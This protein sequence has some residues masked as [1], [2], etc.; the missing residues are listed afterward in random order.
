M[1]QKFPEL[2]GGA[3]L[4]ATALVAAA[5]GAGIFAMATG[6]GA[7]GGGAIARTAGK[8]LPAGKT[9]LRGG[10]LG[11]GAMAGGAGLNAAFGEESAISRYGSSAL[12]GAATGAFIGSVVPVLGTAVG[13]AVG[14]GLGVG[15]ESIKDML[16]PSAEAP[17]MAADIKL[18]VSDERVRVASSNV[19]AS[20]MTGSVQTDTGN[21]W[22]MP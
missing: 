9:L 8:Y 2:T 1:A 6:G 5:G 18:S 17:K 19:T 16:K 4:A 15:W 11:V 7:G 10:A 12:N 14:G 20:G 13:A 21:L 22:G 3:S